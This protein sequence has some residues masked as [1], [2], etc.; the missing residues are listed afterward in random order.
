MVHLAFLFS[1]DVQIEIALSLGGNYN[2][3]VPTGIWQ[4]MLPNGTTTRITMVTIRTLRHD[5]EIPVSVS[6]AFPVES[7]LVKSRVNVSFVI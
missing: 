3:I 7:F 1:I 2:F 4:W 6:T 5:S